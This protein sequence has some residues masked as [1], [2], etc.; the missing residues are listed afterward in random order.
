M[1]KM[2]LQRLFLVLGVVGLGV[3]LIDLGISIAATFPSTTPA[4]VDHVTAGPYHL[5]VSLYTNPANAG[6]ALAFAV[7]PTQAVDG[8]LTYRTASLPGQG[9]DATPVR[10]TFHADPNVRNGIQGAA[11]ITVKG[12]WTLQVTVDGSA[13]QGVANVPIT[14]TALPPIPVWLGWSIGFVPFYVLCVFF[15][16]QL[17]RNKKPEQMGTEYTPVSEVFS[18]VK[19]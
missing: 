4:R 8:L 17:S 15:V 2:F 5:A 18:S 12:P 9:V 11:E 6:Y 7:A 3:V 10:A 1:L 14:A 16:M 13:G 19:E